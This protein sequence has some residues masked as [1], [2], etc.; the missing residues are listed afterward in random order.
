MFMDLM[1][2]DDSGWSIL[3]DIVNVFMFTFFV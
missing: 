2:D 1:R 3:S